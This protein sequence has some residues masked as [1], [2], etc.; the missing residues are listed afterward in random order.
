MKCDTAYRCEEAALHSKFYNNKCTLTV[1][2][3][4]C[5]VSINELI[6]DVEFVIFIIVIV[7]AFRIIIVG[8][9]LNT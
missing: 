5:K 6:V 3:I 4:Q 9:D 1:L 7:N 8:W 2:Y